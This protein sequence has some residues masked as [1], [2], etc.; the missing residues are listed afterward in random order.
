MQPP[1]GKMMPTLLWDSKEPIL[2]HYIHRGTTVNNV[3]CHEMPW[4]WVRLASLT[5]HQ[6]MANKGVA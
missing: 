4:D 6:G 3:Y 1:A 5:D 2:E